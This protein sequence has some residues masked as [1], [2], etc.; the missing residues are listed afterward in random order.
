[1]DNTNSYQRHLS[2]LVKLMT[3]VTGSVANA[4]TGVKVEVSQ[5]AKVEVKEGGGGNWN[6]ANARVFDVYMDN[7]GSQTSQL[8]DIFSC[9]DKAPRIG[10]KRT[11]RDVELQNSGSGLRS[12]AFSNEFFD[13][14]RNKRS[15]VGHRESVPSLTLPIVKVEPSPTPEQSTAAAGTPHQVGGGQ[16]TNEQSGLGQTDKWPSQMES[17]F[18]AALRLII[19]NGTSKFKI[20]DRNYGRN[21]LISLFVQYH[22]H[23]IRTKKQISSHIQ[24]W[25][26]SISNKIA[27]NF[28][29]ND[30][31]KEIL[32]LIEEGAP[33]TNESVKLF[34]STFEEIVSSIV[35][36]E[37]NETSL[38]AAQRHPY[39]TPANSSGMN[40]V[41]QVAIS[42]GYATAPPQAADSL[43]QPSTPA[44]PLEYARS[45]YGNLKT[46]KCVPVKMQEQMTL[47]PGLK[48]PLQPVYGNNS[49][50]DFSNPVLQS[51]KDLELQQRQLIEKLSHTQKS[52][53][54][55]SVSPDLY[56][57]NM[58]PTLQP[59][60]YAPPSQGLTSAPLSHYPLAYHQYQQ[61]VEQVPAGL[62][63]SPHAYYQQPQVY[64]PVSVA[65][66]RPSN[67]GHFQFARLPNNEYQQPRIQTSPPTSSPSSILSND[68]HILRERG[69]SQVNHTQK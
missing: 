52:L 56:I 55:P 13:K 38:D 16:Y 34:Y 33:Q 1:M 40:S 54:L 62:V 6:P 24:V 18:I 27:G 46:Y 5:A 8:L 49:Q 45:I 36:N 63:L 32:Q 14:M 19:K 21:E 28:A 51:A 20:F 58:Q 59:S 17:A 65:H 4:D 35:M 64:V 60:L 47:K 31:D 37:K 42:S 25:K 22:T 10:N 9:D 43:Q 67:C 30:L 50:K 69:T 3:A 7:G 48:T 39:L 26:K 66:G 68:D 44:T 29:I 2:A 41:S 57:R 23:E 12:E 11:E 61:N 53:K 15:R